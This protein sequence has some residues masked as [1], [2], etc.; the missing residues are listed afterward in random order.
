MT[1]SI[2]T[3]LR[4]RR[5]RVASAAAVIALAA[6]VLC[7]HAGIGQTH[8]GADHTGEVIA[9]CLAVATSVVVVA[10]IPPSFP[11]PL[12]RAPRLIRTPDQLLVEAGPV[13]LRAGARASPAGLQVFRL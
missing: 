4:C 7:A 2:R 10:S 1:L 11:Q 13:P 5:T 6:A 3:A 9:I 12:P 8:M